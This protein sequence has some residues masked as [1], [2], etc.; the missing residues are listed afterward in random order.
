MEHSHPLPDGQNWFSGRD[1]QVSRISN[2]SETQSSHIHN[3]LAIHS[4]S[5][6]LSPYHRRLQLRNAGFRGSVLPGRRISPIVGATA[7]AS[8]PIFS[9]LNDENSPRSSERR[10]LYRENLPPSSVNILQE[11][12]NTAQRGH[13]ARTR[14]TRSIS[15]VLMHIEDGTESTT[16]WYHEH[17]NNCSP[18]LLNET[19]STMLKLRNGSLNERTP[20]PLSSPLNKH[21]KGRNSNRGRHRSASSEATK[22]ID[23]LESQLAAVNTKLSALTSPTRTRTQSAKLKALTTEARS[24]RQEVSEWEMKFTERVREGKGERME[25]ELG[26]KARI[27]VVEKELETKDARVKELE[28]EVESM[29]GRVK[30]AE[31]LEEIN[32]NLERRIDVLTELVVQSPT[33]VEISSTTSSPSKRDSSRRTPRPK[34][35]LPRIPSSPGGVRLSLNAITEAN[36]W[37]DRSRDSRSSIAESP[38]ELDYEPF[39]QETPS[40]SVS[41]SQTTSATDSG[42]IMSP[43][44]RSVQSLSSRPTSL[45][46]ST[47][48]Q[49]S[50]WGLPLPAHS[51]YNAQPVNRQKKMRRFPSGNCQLKPLILP[52]AAGTPS[53]P[54]SA[55]IYAYE[56]R[57]RRNF[58]NH[59]MDPTSAFLSMPESSSPI[60]TPTQQGRQRSATWQQKRALDALEGRLDS[61]PLRNECEIIHSPIA[62]SGDEPSKDLV[63]EFRE[64]QRSRAQS[65]MNELERVKN[66]TSETLEDGLMPVGAEIGGETSFITIGTDQASSSTTIPEDNLI[67][68]RLRKGQS[69]TPSP[70]GIQNIKS[71]TS[72]ILT[73]SIPSPSALLRSPKSGSCSALA[74][75]TAQGMFTRLAGVIS[76]SSQNPLIL[77]R[78]F[79]HQAW[80]QGSAQLGGM[81]WWLLGLVFSYRGRKK[82]RLADQK[83]GERP[84]ASGRV[85]S[86]PYSQTA[87]SLRSAEIYLRDRADSLHTAKERRQAR[88]S[89]R[90]ACHSQVRRESMT[91]FDACIFVTPP[92]QHISVQRCSTCVEP[93]SRHTVRLWFRFSLAIILS[94]GIAIKDGPG[95]LLVHTTALPDTPFPKRSKHRP[96]DLLSA[97]DRARSRSD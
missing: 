4:P 74:T 52:T 18:L 9:P 93:P 21:V 88:E 20:P 55:P 33:K 58:T 40:E 68:R 60:S 45:Q 77:A 24:L 59:S 47:S 15:Q 71:T 7:Q 13:Q 44:F 41:E 65:L 80:L 84:N 69:V 87:G 5:E 92:A 42:C 95:A 76:Q 79:L 91:S 36:L 38:E 97:G 19:P 39:H 72:S 8:E 11:I 10:I 94:I 53:L 63:E 34:S 51:E 30:H 85:G 31:A 37:Q 62:M 61:V 56:N 67:R 96:P 81:E 82:K 75:T 28:W 64:L 90:P 78:R 48:M 73:K 66:S 16:S 1:L 57:P 25:M 27:R 89:S 12:H 70:I 54:A 22:Y 35:M 14:G 43:S 26:L 46:S 3:A 83:T 29:A 2:A 6:S 50:S 86:H 49:A 17:S 23:H 32:M